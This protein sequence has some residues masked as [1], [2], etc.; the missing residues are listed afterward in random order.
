MCASGYTAPDV[1]ILHK[2]T[3]AAAPQNCRICSSTLTAP[4]ALRLTQLLTPG[5]QPFFNAKNRFSHLFHL[6]FWLNVPVCV[7][8]AFSLLLCAYFS[9]I[10]LFRSSPNLFRYMQKLNVSL[11]F[12]VRNNITGCLFPHS[13]SRIFLFLQLSKSLSLHPA[14][15]EVQRVDHQQLYLTVVR[16]F[17][18]VIILLAVYSLTH[19]FQLYKS[20]PLRL[21]R[22]LR[23]RS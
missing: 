20:L 5:S 4:T 21:V 6:P 7:L 22:T 2:V 9:R 15:S 3:A 11:Y 1:W 10:F 14:S 12:S 17:R 13:F 19:F 8:G 18:R 16:A 23:G